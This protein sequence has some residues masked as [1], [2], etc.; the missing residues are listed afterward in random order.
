MMDYG[1]IDVE[2]NPIDD[3]T[4]LELKGK[5]LEFPSEIKQK[6]KF[7]EEDQKGTAEKARKRTE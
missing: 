7:E 2:G 3:W 6:R 5:S 4:T 1:I